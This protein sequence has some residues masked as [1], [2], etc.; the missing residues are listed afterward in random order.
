METCLINYKTEGGKQGQVMKWLFIDCLYV[1][2]G[3]WSVL[4][5]M[6]KCLLPF[7]VSGIS[8]FSILCLNSGNM[9]NILA[10]LITPATNKIDKRLWLKKHFTVLKI[11]NW[12]LRSPV[13]GCLGEIAY[14]PLK[15]SIIFLQQ[16][17]ASQLQCW[18]RATSASSEE[19]SWPSFLIWTSPWCLGLW[20]EDA[21]QAFL[22]LINNKACK[23]EMIFGCISFSS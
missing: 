19:V 18:G 13:V 14:W 5:L 4:F 11:S 17:T 16:K 20:G 23:K 8:W 10:M 15:M 2:N 3:T 22:G 1:C 9:L 6:F 12:T 21:D 7:Y